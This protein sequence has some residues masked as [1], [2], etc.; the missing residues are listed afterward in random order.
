MVV[1]LAASLAGPV[2]PGR[3]Q[4]V[5]PDTTWAPAVREPAFPRG[6]GPVVL[7]DE[8]HHERH[9]LGG[10]FAPFG[11]LLE[12]DGYV[13]RSHAGRLDLAAFE[14][15]AVVVI[16]NP[17]AEA[18][19]G[20]WRRP[21]EAAFD[22][23]EIETLAGWVADGGALLLIADHMPFAGAAASLAARFGIDWIDGFALDSAGGGR[24]VFSRSNG[25]LASH[26]I[27]DGRDPAG[28]VDS[29][30][31]F[32]GSAIRGGTGE[33]VLILPSDYVVLVPEEA[34]A[35]DEETPRE[36]ANGSLQGV[37]VE[38]GS[39]RVAAFGEAAMFTAQVV[40][41][42]GAP[43]GLNHPAA[44]GNERF[45]RNVLLWLVGKIE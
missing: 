14:D 38:Y 26:A 35:F 41:P 12:A 29:V 13:A 25:A 10:S 43:V 22:E 42:A 9:T 4:T 33:P 1:L 2:A 39:G 20:R 11:R 16:A 36:S 3:S 31:S 5:H 8:G 23:V 30:M 24:T 18:N 6:A 19:V 44:A 15:V 40:E 7:V 37:V 21:V 17:L 32:S 28:R 45:V 34:W 27:A